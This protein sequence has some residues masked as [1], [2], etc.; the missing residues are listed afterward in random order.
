MD[1]LDETHFDFLGPKTVGKVRDIYRHGDEL[2]VVT[3]DRHSSFDRNIA[4]IPWKGQVLNQVSAWW[5]DKTRDIAPNHLLTIP[6]PNVT[7]AKPCTPLPVEAVVRGYLTGVTDMAAWTRY[8]AGERRFA[9]A[10]L[11]DGMR[12]NQ[13]LPRPFFDPTTKEA[14]HDR[15]LDPEQMIAEGFITESLFERVKE[16][17]LALFARGQEL[18]ARNGL[19]L[20]DTKYEFGVN[21]NGTLTLIDEIH[22][23]DSSRYWQLDSYAAR[24]AAGEEPQYF[25]KEFLRLWFREHCD[26]YHDAALPPAPPELIEELSRRYVAMYEEITGSPFA[27]GETPILPRIEKNLRSYAFSSPIG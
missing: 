27:H 10:M 18:A 19:I 23:P 14:L 9:G 17:A 5:F 21:A 22:T 7:I 11:P 15:A 20:V 12:K 1:I 3:T 2:V 13:K 4:H 24:F 25:D 16:T 6:D 26:P 8:A